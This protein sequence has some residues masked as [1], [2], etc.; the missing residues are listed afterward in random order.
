MAKKRGGSGENSDVVEVLKDL[1][2]TQLGVAGVPQQTI[3]AIVGCGIDRVNRIVK[4]LK[5]AKRKDA[6]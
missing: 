1:L 5:A 6:D 2:I 3:R 4:H